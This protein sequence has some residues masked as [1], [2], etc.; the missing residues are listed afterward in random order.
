MKIAIINGTDA[1][2]LEEV[3]SEMS[4][5]GAP[6][7]KAVWMECYGHWAALEGSHRVVAAKSLGI[8]PI[9]D[10]I[11]YSSEHCPDGQC[12]MTIEQICDSSN[13]SIVIEF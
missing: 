3:K 4:K 6:V 1:K 7:I 12:E 11:E 5:I 13:Q 8:E 9:I 2:H 10:A